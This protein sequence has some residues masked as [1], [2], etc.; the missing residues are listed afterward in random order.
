MTKVIRFIAVLAVI[1]GLMALP[2]VPAGAGPNSAGVVVFS[3]TAVVGVATTLGTLKPV[4][5]P[6]DGD[7][8]C[9]PLMWETTPTC[10]GPLPPLGGV[11]P[12]NGFVISVNKDLDLPAPGDDECVS[13]GVLAGT[14]A[15]DPA[16]HILASGM[17]LIDTAPP[18]NPTGPACGNSEGTTLLLEDGTGAV[19]DDDAISI[20]GVKHAI[21]VKWPT[22]AGSVL[23]IM[24][25]MDVD[26]VTS[27]L[28]F[29]GAADPHDF[30][31]LV[32]ARPKQTMP[33]PALPCVD[34]PATKFTVA[35]TIE[36]LNTDRLKTPLHSP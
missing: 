5:L 3:G 2:S 13:A 11:T 12:D 16:C 21:W 29:A 20:L 10:T 26:A 4:G 7:G 9:L 28:P 34:Y 23:P 18:G 36:L 31:G 1:L 6:L 27:P 8:L 17:V 19:D 25:Q 22:S 15:V 30:V 33:L 35:G 14:P 32:N 24:G